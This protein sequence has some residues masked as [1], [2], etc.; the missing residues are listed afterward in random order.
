M[1]TPTTRTSRKINS[2]DLAPPTQ[3][4]E[5]IPGSATHDDY[6]LAIEDAID[7]LILPFKIHST[8]H[9]EPT[10]EQLHEQELMNTACI[11]LEKKTKNLV[12]EDLAE[13]VRKRDEGYR[14]ARHYT[15]ASTATTQETISLADRIQVIQYKLDHLPE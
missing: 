10:R 14:K 3:G 6:L 4:S 1:P 13:S 2:V 7:S 8:Q 5:L 11:S 9:P 12:G 15:D